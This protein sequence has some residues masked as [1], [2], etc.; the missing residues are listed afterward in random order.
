MYS[1]LSLTKKKKII[2]KILHP[3]TFNNLLTIFHLA[4]SIIDEINVHYSVK[5]HSLHQ[6]QLTPRLNICCGQYFQFDRVRTQVEFRLFSRT[7]LLRNWRHHYVCMR[8]CPSA[9]AE[10]GPTVRFL[11]WLMSRPQINDLNCKRFDI[12]LL[13]LITTS[14]SGFVLILCRMAWRNGSNLFPW[15]FCSG[16]RGRNALFRQIIRNVKF[17]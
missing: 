3:C 11:L 7:E 4:L 13:S 17:L 14:V 15:L 12:I 6:V 5:F 9:K 16:T 10:S 2:Y 1:I 8:I